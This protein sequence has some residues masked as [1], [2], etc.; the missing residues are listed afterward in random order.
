M[1]VS[2]QGPRRSHYERRKIA[3]IGAGISGNM[4]AYLLHNAHDIT[5]FEK[6]AR[7]GGHSAT[8]DI[9][10]RAGTQLSVDTGFIVY[11]EH[12]Y[13]GLVRLFREL[14]IPTQASTMS[15]A[16]SA[17]NGGYEWSGQSLKH[18]FAQKRNILRPRFWRMLRDIL[19]FNRLA[20]EQSTI[21]PH[22]SLQHWL[23]DH[24]FGESFRSTYLYPMAAA[25]WSTPGDDIGHFPASSLIAFFKNHRLTERQRPVWRTV[26]GGSRTYVDRLT[27]LFADNI[28]T[29]AQITAVTRTPN[30]VSLTF[31]DGSIQDFDDVIFAC[32]S[33]QALTLLADA[34]DEEKRLLE[35]ICYRPNDVYLHCDRTLMPKRRSIWSSWNYMA[36]ER[37]DTVCVSYWMN[38]LQHID[39]AY[40]IF[41]TLNPDQPPAPELTY[42]HYQYDHPQFNGAAIQAQQEIMAR[43]GDRNTY[44]CG[45]WLGY[46]FH[47]DGLQSAVKLMQHFGVE[48]EAPKLS[49]QSIA[50]K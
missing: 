46:G 15:F 4:A 17:E 16:F 48:W 29:N 32:H 47:E 45:A 25:I 36:S 26:R 1:S 33:D 28:Q 20:R 35:A 43:Q 42:G 22:I 19:R 6:R 10:T 8:R 44:F 37:S 24:G 34:S 18:V 14:D 9:T 23:D 31:E 5:V 7:L 39:P 50:A 30:G 38:R 49:P 3:I 21:D 12:N 27:S 13:P 40:P 2:T 11:N 41:V